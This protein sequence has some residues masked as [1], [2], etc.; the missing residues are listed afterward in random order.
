[1]SPSAVRQPMTIRHLF[2]MTAGFNYDINSPSI[3]KAK[4]YSRNKAD[5]RT[6]IDALAEEPLDFVP[7][8]RY[9]YSFCHDVLAAVIEEA[10]P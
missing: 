5:T 10:K 6:M 2:T 4:L 8:T 3:Q 1:M 7:G 9:Q